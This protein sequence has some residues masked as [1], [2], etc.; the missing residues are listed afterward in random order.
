MEERHTMAAPVS[1]AAEKMSSWCRVRLA[2]FVLGF[3][4]MPLSLYA[5]PGWQEEWDRVV[6]AGKREGRVSVLGTTGTDVRDALAVSFQKHY[7][8]QVEFLGTTGAQQSARVLTERRAGKYLWDVF[9]GGIGTGL[10]SLI[11]AGAFDPLE[12]ALILPDIKDP[13]NW[14]GGEME[15]ADEGRTFLVMTPTQRVTL[16]VNS[17]LVDPK[18]FKSH[19]DLL[20]PKWK[21]RIVMDDPRVAGAGQ[22]TFVFFYLHPE[23]GADFIRALGRQ[24]PIVVKDATQSQ[25]MLGQGKYPILLGPRDSI[26][27]DAI[28]RGLPIAVVHPYQLREGTDVSSGAGNAA[29]FNQAPHPHAARV[30]INWLLSKEGQ[31]LYARALAYVSKRLD[32]PNDYVEPWRVPQPGAIKTYTQEAMRRDKLMALLTETFGR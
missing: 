19:K 8:I 21:G 32:V 17:Q 9:V 24:E 20:D 14:R 3:V 28:R 11:P 4:G 12:P 30:Y 5:A 6:A 18:S 25:S 27:L 13:K 22:A 2:L 16:A 10:M 26:L 7:G 15:F 29:L 31:Y 1:A 23:L